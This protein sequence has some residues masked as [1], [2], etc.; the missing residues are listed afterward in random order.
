LLGKRPESGGALE[1]GVNAEAF[2]R[3]DSPAEDVVG[4]HE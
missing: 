4:D 1:A 3:R 2:T